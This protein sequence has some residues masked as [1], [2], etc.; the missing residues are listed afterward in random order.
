MK[1]A[2]RRGMSMVELLVAMALGLV[3]VLA[4]IGMLLAS[5]RAWVTQVQAASV[6]D[7]ARYA[8]AAIE[9]AAR[10]SAYVDWD[11]ADAASDPDPAAPPA[12]RG[13]DAAS[14]SAAAHALNDPRPAAINGSDVLALRFSGA[15]EGEGDGSVATCAG[16]AVGAGQE[17]WSIFY[18]GMSGDG[19]PEL[20]CKYRGANNWSADA[21]ISGVDSFQV[22]YGVDTDTVA[23]GVANSFLSASVINGM[24]EA[25][26][27]AG[28]NDEARERDRQRRS[29]WKRVASIKVA[30]ILHGDGG[31][32]TSDG[33][34]MLHAFGAA[35]SQARGDSDTGTRLDRN[36]MDPK[37]Q[38]RAHRVFSATILLRNRIR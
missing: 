16:F 19:R 32:A 13:L 26:V 34:R 10:Q 22:L 25:L 31:G 7:A 2:C 23:D 9:R 6:D 27:G 37:L 14:L 28:A 24:D 18:V 4:A 33:P 30:L 15:G 5:N 17:G 12:V 36:A 38:R 20:R 21:V 29:W 3:V 11:R 1:A 8:L 35:Y